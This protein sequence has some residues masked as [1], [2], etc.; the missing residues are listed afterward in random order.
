MMIS[1]Q[2]YIACL[3]LLVLITTGI[4]Y[5][6][7]LEPQR[8]GSRTFGLLISSMTIWAFFYLLE[9]VLPDLSQK[10]ITRKI[11]YLGMTLS[12]PFWLAFAFRYTVLSEWWSKHGRIALLTIPGVIA[13]SLGLTNEYHHFIWQSL[14]MPVS[15]LS[16]LEITYGLGFWVY[17]VISYMFIATGIFIYIYVYLRSPKYLRKQTG[18]ILL[19]VLVTVI[20]NV[21][22][23]AGIF[24]SNIDPT[25]LSFAM[26]APLLAIGFFR[27]G[28]F[29]LFPI[30]APLIIENL[31]D[32]VIAVDEQ[33]HITNINLAAK[34]WFNINDNKIGSPV[35]EILPKP[36]MFK[37]KWDV[38]D[39]RVK[40]KM[41]LNGQRAWY[42]ATITHLHKSDDTLLGRVIV[43]HDITHEQELL[44]AEFRHSTQM[45][46]LEEV[47]R[48]ISDNLTEKDILQHSVNAIVN[49]FGYAEAAISILTKDNR[50]EVTAINGT[51][52]FGY[53]P[54][55]KQE[56]G[57]G[58]IGH[59]AEIKKT[60]IANDVSKDPY[61]FSSD[62]RYG[63][64][65]CIPLINE[66]NLLGVLYIESAKP[67][68]FNTDDI[69][70]LETLVNQIASAIQ[71]ARLY[72]DTRE[73]LQVMSAVQSIAQVISSSLD[74]ER[75]CASVVNVLNFSFGYTH[76]SIYLLEND[77]LHLGAQIG[78]SEE[79]I[80]EKIHVS[81]GISGRT[82]ETKK[83]QFIQ[84]VTKEPD[85]IRTSPD[86]ISEIC[87]PLL[88]DNTILGMLNV[89]GMIDSPITQKDADM[90]NILAGPIALAVDNARLHAQ[91]KI[92][93]MTDAVSGLSNRHAFEETLQT[94]IER[95]IRSNIPLS[96][97][98]FDLD[99]FK[100]YND[101]W[102]HPAGDK[103]LKATA[104]LI[105]GNLRKYDVAARYGGD[106]FAI[107]LPDTDQEGSTLFAKRLLA[108]AQA[109][110]PESATTGE[111]VAG[112]TLSI[113]VATFPYNGN[114]FEA[115]V[116]A[117]DHAE[118]IAKRLGKNRIIIASD[119]EK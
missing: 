68:A 44:E 1:L 5:R 21:I 105:R 31:R 9:I 89:E 103:R 107:I 67:N 32:A 28:L 101:T 26:T 38:I 75:I 86:V 111:A 100:V 11:L 7:F 57:N 109:S 47:G 16:P 33:N 63:S 91:V 96:L 83:T 4:I 41:E 85:F 66:K 79:L 50:L 35:F 36:N 8:A 43:F 53:K 104:D 114:T 56:I 6:V 24:P 54:A 55:F 73:H 25:P 42:D 64:A 18:I 74:L 71:R 46:L 90:L 22:F 92:I 12:G 59:T 60:Y 23:L 27:F 20:S 118:L 93:A 45:G 110:A 49:H 29:N 61:Y 94:E 116:L 87:V 78:F 80:L 13:F 17:A 52:D 97:I 2:I 102:G 77:Y 30:A 62:E 106:E 113:G 108:A 39:A 95:A 98:I 14:K 112:Y 34:K 37:D 15:R 10:I 58:I 70:T 40:F 51:Q 99:S 88:K 82:I 48:Q 72:A 81:Q 19:G 69:Q 65:I 76:I 117:A 84:D 115:L 3:G 119:L